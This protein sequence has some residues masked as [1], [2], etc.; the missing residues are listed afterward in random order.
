MTRFMRDEV[1]AAFH[2]YWQTG[3]VSERWSDWADL[4]T[5]DAVYHERVLG[6]MRGREQIRE[7]I[8]PIMEEYRE[9]YTAYEWHMLD[10]TGRVV[11]YM[12]NRRDHPSGEGSIDFPGITI[13][14]YAG[15]GKWS[16]EE[17]Y[18]A[19]GLSR[20]AIKAYQEACARFDPEHKEKRTRLHWGNGPDWTQGARSYFGR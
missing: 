5:E 9:L 4:F 1:E 19:I 11:V 8:I 16:Y 15:D 10:E 14:G 7:W 20:S 13:L 3:A 17:D 12:Q 6:S 18:W 2:R